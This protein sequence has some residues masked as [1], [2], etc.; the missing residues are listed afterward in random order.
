MLNGR[1]HFRMHRSRT[2]HVMQSTH[3]EFYA[4]YYQTKLEGGRKVALIKLD[5]M[6]VSN[7]NTLEMR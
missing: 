7:V 2:M 6:Q 4:H 5:H 1:M 3:Y